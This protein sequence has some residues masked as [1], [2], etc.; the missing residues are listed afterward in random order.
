MGNFHL[1]PP[2][3]QI[4][5]DIGNFA[6]VFNVPLPNPSRLCVCVFFAGNVGSI[7]TQMSPKIQKPKHL[8]KKTRKTFLMGSAGAD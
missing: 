4:V 8:A 3:N 1:L 7:K 6:H 2:K 5:C